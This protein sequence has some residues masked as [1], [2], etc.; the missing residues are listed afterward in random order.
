MNDIFRNRVEAGRRLAEKLAHYANQPSVLVLAMPRGGV[1]V[2]FEVAKALRVPLDVFVVRKLGTPG[3]PELA[4]G[5]IATGGIRVLNQEVIGGL[6]ISA[7]MIDAV[8]ADET[9][10]LE[11]R[12][13]AYR[14]GY[15][16][17]EIR[18]KEVILIDDGIATG[19]TVRAAVRALKA[20]HPARLIIAVP[21]A[22][23]SAYRELR[24]EA[25]ELVALMTPEEFYG[26]GEW[27]EDFSQTSDEQVTDLLRQAKSWQPA[28]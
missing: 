8:T 20:Q 24:P 22:A 6:S 21:V 9:R 28:S 26:V 15:S 2:G 12:E 1:P 4:M 16:L 18:G 27:Y 13:L 3:R 14:S 10:E 17:P 11:R 19:S 25:D 7:A 5:A 23:G